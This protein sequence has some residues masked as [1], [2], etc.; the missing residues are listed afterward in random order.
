MSKSTTV[1][2]ATTLRVGDVCLCLHVQRAARALARRFDEALR[3]VGLTNGQFS[4]LMA[5]NHPEPHSI[6][7][8]AS[9]LAMDRTTLTAALKPLERR[10]LVAISPDPKDRRSRRI[11]LTAAGHATLA[12]A[13]PIWQRTHALVEDSLAGSATRLRGDLRAL[14]TLDTAPARSRPA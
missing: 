9:R 2:D 3:P 13:L 1:A 11:G 12:A 14:V 7:T 6:G 10:G 8:V 4:L 5:L